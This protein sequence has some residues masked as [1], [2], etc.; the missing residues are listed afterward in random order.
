METHSLRLQRKKRG[1]E[2]KGKGESSLKLCK[3]IRIKKWAKGVS[4]VHHGEVFHSKEG[5]GPSSNNRL[6]VYVK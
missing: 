3:V 6:A 2:K 5:K 4:I 1:P